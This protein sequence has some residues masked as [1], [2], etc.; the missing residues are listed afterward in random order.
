MYPM[1]ILPLTDLLIPLPDLYFT[2][3]LLITI[4]VYV[5]WLIDFLLIQISC[6]LEGYQ[7]FS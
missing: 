7:F 5:D 1:M 6:A 4:F 3:A 2:F